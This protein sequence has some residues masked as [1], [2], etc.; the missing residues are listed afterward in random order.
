MSGRAHAGLASRDRHVPTTYRLDPSSWS[1]YY[2]R[3]DPM[4]NRVV[5]TAVDQKVASRPDFRRW[6]RLIAGTSPPSTESEKRYVRISQGTVTAVLGRAI[7]MAATLA[8]IP[9]TVGYLGPERYGVWVTLGSV[10]TWLQLADLGLPNGLTNAIAEA[11]ARDDRVLAQRYVAT[12]YWA[13]TALSLALIALFGAAHAYVNWPRILGSMSP[14]A[15]REISAAVALAFVAFM[16]SF[17]LAITDRVYI[18]HQEGAIANVWSILANLATVAGVLVVIRTRG[19]LPALVIASSG[20]R[21][22]VSIASTC[23]LVTVH[24]PYLFPLPSRFDR[25][26]WRR[27]GRDGARLAII[28]I[29]AM[30]LFSTDNYIIARVLGASYVT[31]YSVTWSLFTI[32]QLPATLMFSYLWAAYGDAIARRDAVWV[33][34]TFRRTLLVFVGFSAAMSVP[35]ALAGAGVIREWVGEVA[36]APRSVFV[37][38]AVWSIVFAYMNGLACLLNANGRFR[39]QTLYGSSTA[40]LNIV[41]SVWWAREYGLP[42]VIAGTVVS[43]LAVAVVPASLESFRVVRDLRAAAE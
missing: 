25:S 38:M 23:W 8:T 37:W 4:L 42:G 34:H 43:Y 40:V 10:L 15:A 6:S 27:L 33:I 36:V 16:L 24:R 32:P 1:V 31:P 35:L 29:A 12:A 5:G 22:L 17:P 13:L 26:A 7:G 9:L 20:V 21:L 30:L 41:L 3:P 14:T 39:G 19:G 18:A 28:Q 11:N 2:R